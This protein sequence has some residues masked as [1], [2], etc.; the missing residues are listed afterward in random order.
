MSHLQKFSTTFKETGDSR[1]IYQNKSD[2][3]FFMAYGDSK[4][5]FRT[6]V[7]DK[8]LGDKAFNTD[9]NPK[10]DGYRKCLASMI[11]NFFDKKTFGGAI[12][13]ENMFNKELSERIIQNNQHISNLRNEKNTHLL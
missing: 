1:Y 5:L 3:A 11:Y 2:K 9:N 4:A 7:S 10:Y 6:T 8:I 13:D 12:K